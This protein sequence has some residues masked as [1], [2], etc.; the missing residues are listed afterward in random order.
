MPDEQPLA[1]GLESAAALPGRHRAAQLVGLA[2]VKSAA[3]IAICI[4]CSW[5]I[6]TPSVRRSTSASAAL[7]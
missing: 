5:K 3:T 4:T 2:G 1:E 7:G 6:G